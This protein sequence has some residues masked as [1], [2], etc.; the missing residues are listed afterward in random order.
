MK[1]EKRR[2]DPD[3][4]PEEPR[5]G[6]TTSEMKDRIQRNLMKQYKLVHL[7]QLA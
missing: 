1:N 5:K 2:P 3:Y 4:I 6:E 7:K